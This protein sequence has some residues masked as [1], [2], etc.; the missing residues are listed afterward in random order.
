MDIININNI[1]KIGLIMVKIERDPIY[2]RRLIGKKLNILLLLH[3]LSI[4][5]NKFRPSDFEGQ[6][7]GKMR[8]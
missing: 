1:R 8:I 5:M 7:F 3:L 4:M 2:S 6:T